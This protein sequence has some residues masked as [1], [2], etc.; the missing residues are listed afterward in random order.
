V[1][2]IFN[3]LESTGYGEI[4]LLSLNSRDY[5]QLEFLVSRLSEHLSR[6][7]ISISLP[8]LR[9]DCPYGEIMHSQTIRPTQL[10]FA[11][12]VA[13][14]SLQAKINKCYERESFERLVRDAFKDGLKSMK[15]YYM[16]GLPFEHEEDVY[17]IPKMVKDLLK[18][19]KSVRRDGKLVV[20]ISPFTPKPHTPFQ[21]AGQLSVEELNHRLDILKSEL[22]KKSIELR[23]QDI[24]S[25]WLECLLSR[26]DRK[27]GEVI[28]S[29]YKLGASFDGWSDK[30]KIDIWKEAFNRTAVTPD[31]YIKGPELDDEL[32]WGHIKAGPDGEY[33]KNEWKKSVESK[34]TP[35]CM[36]RSCRECGVCDNE[37]NLKFASP[38][39]DIHLPDVDERL[40]WIREHTE[41]YG[42]GI[43][44]FTFAKDGVGIYLSN[45]DILRAFELSFRRAGIPIKYSQGYNPRPKISL[46]RALP[47]GIK[48]ESELG[49]IALREPFSPIEFIDRVNEKMPEGLILTNAKILGEGA[50]QLHTFDLQR[51]SIRVPENIGRE[52]SLVDKITHFSLNRTMDFERTKG[53]RTFTLKNEIKNLNAESNDGYFKI[54]VDIAISSNAPS[55]KIEEVTG[56]FIP[57][58]ILSE[59]EIISEGI[60]MSLGDD[61]ISPLDLRLLGN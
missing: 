57:E 58:D 7:N 48:A 19:V 46:V 49:E 16:I 10:T 8:S 50:P 35:P 32:P 29:A 5:S 60:F 33:L 42:K 20:H 43:I 12:E 27:I 17:E 61:I 1:D 56:L 54:T 31:I 4:S 52:L 24:E 13:S 26:G 59:T 14:E 15:L 11:P 23:W 47:I 45:L 2:I 37:L 53:V 34:P 25:S 51:V 18:V 40:R 44:R 55:L 30:L 9:V 3:S 41:I 38:E 22:P 6:S 28:Q 36:D 21:W 39:T